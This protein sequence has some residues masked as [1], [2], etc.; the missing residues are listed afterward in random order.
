MKMMTETVTV[1]EKNTTE[2][3]L[4][5]ITNEQGMMWSRN[6]NTPC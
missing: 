6:K 1:T 3:T 5:Q 2:I 4:G